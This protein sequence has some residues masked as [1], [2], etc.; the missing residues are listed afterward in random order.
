MTLNASGPISLGGPTTG[1][2]INLELGNAATAVASI[3]SAPFRTLANVP[4]GA[5]ALSNFY[6]KSANSYWALAATVVTFDRGFAVS[7]NGIMCIGPGNNSGATGANCIHFFNLDGIL[8]KSTVVN[9]YYDNLGGYSPKEICVGGNV[10]NNNFSDP[11]FYPIVAANLYTPAG[12]GAF[13]STSNNNFQGSNKWCWGT[14]NGYDYD[15]P[16]KGVLFDSSNNIYLAAHRPTFGYSKFTAYQTTCFSFNFTGTARWGIR[17]GGTYA[18]PA[19]Q[20]Q[21]AT[22]RTDNK[23]V[24]IGCGRGAGPAEIYLVNASSGEFIQ[25]Y[26]YTHT[27]PRGVYGNFFTD[28]SNNVYWCTYKNSGFQTP[29]ISKI[30]SSYVGSAV[31]YYPSPDGAAQANW[32][33]SFSLYNGKI[34][35]FA[36]TGS[37][38]RMVIVQIDIATMLPEWTL[39]MTFSGSLNSR[40]GDSGKNTIYATSVGIYI[41]INVNGFNN[42]F[43]LPLDG[44]ISGT[45]SVLNPSGAT[46]YNVTF[47]KVTSG[48]TMCGSSPTDFTQSG[49]GSTNYITR[50]AVN[51]TGGT[52]FNGNTPSTVKSTL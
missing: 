21:M 37:A 43:K 17:N 24:V 13:T 25:S 18:N 22:L 41:A 20:A 1:Q 5:I 48:S 39:N 6:G 29:V 3:D 26:Q 12:T 23:V 40:M 19:F 50:T 4:S 36:S 28:S 31:L 52:P 2:S 38:T 32:F 44:A 15:Y 8:T 42:Y 34:Y 51:A 35:M 45:K 10:N 7:L 30:S 16:L 14:Q 46:S 11:I 49:G 33:P 27:E 47:S 9:S